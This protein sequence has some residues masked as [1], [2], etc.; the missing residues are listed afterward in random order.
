M[1]DLFIKLDL[2][3]AIDKIDRDFLDPVLHAKG[4]GQP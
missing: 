4:F 1:K 2:E 3:K